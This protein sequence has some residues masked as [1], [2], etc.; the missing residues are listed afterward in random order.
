MGARIADVLFRTDVTSLA[1]AP[2]ARRAVVRQ[3]A[4][5]AVSGLL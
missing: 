5:A 4:G 2:E 1:L 3:Q